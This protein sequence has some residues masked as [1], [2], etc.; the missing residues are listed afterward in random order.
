MAIKPVNLSHFKK[1]FK[2]RGWKPFPFQTQL[3]ETYLDGFSGILNAPTGSGKSYAM[4][5]PILLEN[6][7]FPKEKKPGLKVLWITPVRALAADLKLALQSAADDF[8]MGW[9]VAARTGDTSQK[10]RK[11]HKTHPPQCLIITP[12]SIHVLLAQKDYANLFSQLQTVVV[13]EW[14]E[15]LGTKRGVQVE[16]ALSRLKTLR[17]DL[18]IW[19][20]SATIGNLEQA[21]EVLLG[22]SSSA[23]KSI[24]IQSDI[25]KKIEV[26]AILPD[27]I[28]KYPWAGH[29]GIRL[30]PKI[31]PIIMA[32]KTTLLF[33]N[34]RSQCEIWYQRLLETEPDLAGIIALHHGSLSQEIR[35]WV[36]EALHTERLKVV[37]C[38]SSLDL[39]VDFRPVETI[40]QVGSPKGVARFLQRAGRSGHKPGAISKIY[41]VP[42]HSLELIEAAALRTAIKEN[43][44]ES[45]VPVVRAFDVLIQYLMTLAVSDGFEESVI[46]QE[47][48][49]TH[50]FN[51]MSSDEWRAVLEFITSGGP[52]LK[53]YTEYSK[54]LIEN[55]IYKIT[56]KRMAMRH[57]L[58]IG[59]IVSDAM[60]HVKYLKGGSIGLIEE[61]FIA[62]LKPGEAFSFGGRNLEMLHI[63]DM[64]VVV[65]NTKIKITT[66]PQWMGGRMNLS[67]MLTD[68]IRH[69]LTEV[70]ENKTQDIELLALA[71]LFKK[72][73]EVSLIPT[74]NQFLIESFST[75]EG[76]HLFFYTFEGRY[77][78]E[79]LAALI[80]HRLSKFRP[81]SF[82]IAMTDYGFELLSD[83]FFPIEE[84][85]EENIF[86]ED[87]LFTDIQAGLNGTEMARR[88][89]RNIAAISGLIFTGFPGKSVKNRHLQASARLFFD[90]FREHE[91]NHLLLQQAMDEV[92]FD[93]LDEVRLRTALKRINSQEIL[94][95]YPGKPTP[96][97]FPILVEKFREKSSS[98]KMEDR[99]KRMIAQLEK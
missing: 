62:R 65:R 71:P 28:E 57:R 84:A 20:I 37:V 54:V 29:L 87:E 3:L 13:D 14:H 81:S 50:A 70:I 90:V 10:D 88:K 82:S 7:S 6:L 25:V 89:F 93:Q 22:T 39:G 17:K 16:L 79:G 4:W 47:I 53:A 95:V 51:S 59:T 83:T 98:E 24:L 69:K 32:G 94:V 66:I 64:H 36:E 21:M 56:D 77:V 72:Q 33:T 9:K 23:T 68:M 26:E 97:S 75:K 60:L 34:T 12:E 18:K 52:S 91:P 58:S 99:V 80:A 15:L 61:Y 96:F 86:S 78:N 42:A 55:G 38:T 2:G 31:L 85:L 41:F 92:M 45:R 11:K 35:T 30:L 1:W 40:I 49:N 74:E 73:Q 67:S 19:G 44:I 46:Y 8:N 48:L 76:A 5:I 27:E 63:R 43:K